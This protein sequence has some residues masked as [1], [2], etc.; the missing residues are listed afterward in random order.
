MV[1]N[2]QEQVEVKTLPDAASCDAFVTEKYMPAHLGFRDQ[3]KVQYI[4][5]TLHL[6]P[7]PAKLLFENSYFP[8]LSFLSVKLYLSRFTSCVT[9]S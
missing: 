8:N 3:K 4:S 6:F 1:L 2:I 7:I 9:G 5:E